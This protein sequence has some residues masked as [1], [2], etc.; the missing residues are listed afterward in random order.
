MALVGTKS[1]RQGVGARL[2]ART[3]SKKQIREVRAGGGFL[4]SSSVPTAFG[5]GKATLVDELTIRWPSGTVQ[6]LRDVPVN[7]MIRVTESER[8]EYTK[9]VAGQKKGSNSH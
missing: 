2:T 8:N 9:V 5:L 7:Q 4:S 3:G 6:T 1:N